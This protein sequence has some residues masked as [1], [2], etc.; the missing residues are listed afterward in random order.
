VTQPHTF[1][2]PT[3]AKIRKSKLGGAS[4]SGEYET[5]MLM[6]FG[7]PIDLTGTDDRDVVRVCNEWV[8]G[9]MAGSGKVS[10]STWAL[11]T[12]D[13]GA[14][15]DPTCA[16]AET[17]KACKDAIVE[18]YSRFLRFFWELETPVR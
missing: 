13:S 4:H 7:Y 17:G 10:W 18:E 3:F 11:Q 16:S 6:H 8:A 9:D 14:L 12:T 15:G 5:S 2:V 1:V